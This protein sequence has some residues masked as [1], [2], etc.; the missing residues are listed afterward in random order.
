MAR[1]CRTGSTSTSGPGSASTRSSD[2][3]QSPA[4]KG[5][6]ESDLV[7]VLQVS[8]DRQPGGQTRDLE[9]H[10]AQQAGQVGGRRLSLEV[11]VGGDDDL[12]DVSI[13]QPGQ[14]LL[15]PQVVRTNPF[16]RADRT[17]EHV[18]APP[19]LAGPLDSHDVLGLFDDADTGQVTTGVQADAALF[20]FGDVAADVAEADLLLDLH[21]RFD[22]PVHIDRVGPQQMERDAL[23]ALGTDAWKSSELVDQVLDHA[24]IHSG[25]PI[26]WL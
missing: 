8:T 18:V 14:Q 21:Q 6:T 9:V 22:E 26:P 20:G 24:F 1:P 11:G 7:G 3:D 12:A 25:E 23:R 5:P 4:F 10:G 16:D 2:I 13:G 17:A 19:E 15:D